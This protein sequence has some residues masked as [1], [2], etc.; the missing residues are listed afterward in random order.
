MSQ[1][2]IEIR[3]AREHNLQDINLK[4]PKDQLIV[5]TG[6]S[7]SGK[8][9]LAIDTI[10]AEGQRRYIESLSTYARQF[11]G[12]IEKPKFDTIDGLSP[13]ISI[14]QKSTSQ[15]PRSTVATI[16]EIYDYLRVLFSRAGKLHCAEC[17][18][19][20]GR[21]TEDE[22]VDQIMAM[23]ENRRLLILA[24]IVIGRR[25][26][27]RKELED[28]RK[29]G[30]ARARI[31]GVVVDLMEDIQLERHKRHN[32]EI[33]VDRIKVRSDI[34]SRVA[35]SVEL[36]LRMSNG[37]LTVNMLDFQDKNRTFSRSYTCTRCQIGYQPLAPRDFSFNSPAGMCPTCRGVG[38]INGISKDLVIPDPDLSINNGAVSL[39]GKIESSRLRMMVQSLADY[40]EIDLNDSWKEL[41]E[42]VQNAILYGTGSRRIPM[43][44]R[45]RGRHRFKRRE[46][47]HGVIPDAEY[48]YH[49]S[50]SQARKNKFEKYVSIIMCPD[51]NGNRLKSEAMS[52][53][54]DDK[55]IVDIAEMT[56][57][58]CL[59]FFNNLRLAERE[60]IIAE[61][62][63]REIRG[64]LEFLANV[65]LEYLSL[66]RTAPTLSG[67]E[68]QRIR[69][70][71]QIG[72]GLHDVV[73]VL[74]EPSIGLHPRDN[75][76][77]LRTLQQL[78]NQGNTVIV[79]EHDEDTMRTADM[80]VDFGPRA[81]IQGGM[82]SDIGTPNEVI[83][84]G[85][86]LTAQYL[87]GDLE[88]EIPNR[89]R[90]HEDSF[91]EII[92][93]KHNNLKNIDVQIPVGILTCVTGVSGSGKSSLI[94]D[95]LYQALARDL[96]RADTT[97][98]KHKRIQAIK[99]NENNILEVQEVSDVIDKVVAINQSPIGRIPRSNPA[100]Y[101]KLFDHIRSLFAGLPE[102]KLRGYKPGRFSFN[103]KGGRCEACQGNGAKKIELQ[104]LADVWVA[105]N[106][107]NGKRYNQETLTVK[108]K[109]KS[110]SDVLN[111]DVQEALEHFKNV[112]NIAKILQT[113]Y[114]VGLDYIKLGQPSPTLS[115]G[116]AQRIKLSRELAKRRTDQTLYILDEPTTGLHFDDV[117]RLL[118]VLHRL[119]DQGSTVI[120]IEHNLEVIKTADYI[121]DLG[122]E[123]GES[124]GFVVA[125]G[126]PEEV[127]QIKGSHTGQ[128]LKRL[129]DRTTEFLK[130]DL[131]APHAV[132]NNEKGIIVQGASEHNL[133][134]VDVKIPYRKL[135]ALTGVSGS[136]KSSLALDII[137]AE[138]QR[139]YIESLSTYARQFLGQL[140]K[141]KVEKI[142]GLSPAI[143]IER[144]ALSKNPRSTVGTV[145]EIYDYLRVLY[146]RIGRAHCPQCKKPVGSQSSQQIIDKIM[147]QPHGI[148]I[149]VMSPLKLQRGENYQEAFKRLQRLGFARVE[150][151]NVTHLLDQAPD[152]KATSKYDVKIVVDR[153]VAS[154]EEKSRLAEA[155]ETA[156]AQ[157]VGTVAIRRESR[158]VQF[159]RSETMGAKE[160]SNRRRQRRRNQDNQNLT[161]TTQ[162]GGD[163][164]IVYST[165]FAC[166]PCSLSFDELTPQHFSFNSSIGQC[167]TCSG[168]GTIWGN[169]CHS[170]QGTRLK[171]LASHVTIG[172]KTISELT[173]M[174]IRQTVH[175][176]NEIG[177][178]PHEMEIGR[179]LVAETRKRLQFL[180][181]IGLHYLTLNRRAPTISG[182]EMQRVHLASQLGSGLTGI[183]YVL[184]EPTTGLHQRDNQRLIKALKGLRDLGN[185]VL[186]IEHDPSTIESSDHVLDFGPGAGI[187]GGEII[188][189]GSPSEIKRNS[190]SLTGRYLSKAEEISIPKERRQGSGNWLEIKHAKKNNLK[191]INVKI[192]F[193]TLTCVTGV[194]GSGKS[195]LVDGVLL[196]SSVTSIGDALKFE[197]REENQK[198]DL[199]VFDKVIN[200]DQSPIGETPRSNAAT[201]TDMFTKI[202]TLFASLPDAKVRGFSSGR[203]SFN[204]SGGR[205][206][207][208]QGLG[209]NQIEMHFLADVWLEC[210]SC[211]GTGYNRETLEVRY[212]GKN[213][214]DI[215]RMPV[216]EALE[217]FQDIPT[218]EKTLQL[219]F[220]VGLDYIQL[221]Q[222][223]TTLS[224]GESQRI[225]L[226]AELGK[227]STGKTLYVMD[228]PTTGLH[229][230]DIQKLLNVINRLVNKG[231]TIVIIEHNMDVIKS[232]D[233][234]I[235]L[236]P[237][238]G[239][240]GGYLIAMGTPEEVASIDQS[241]TGLFLRD[242]LT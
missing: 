176:F 14:S 128:Y 202:R 51:C 60:T 35:E 227:R 119:V 112:P 57:N 45:Q 213:I 146:S 159:G 46:A 153:L 240:E 31:N 42:N 147:D 195:S 217:I 62:V 1:E 164:I 228:E 65:G 106:V 171:P 183:T 157:S 94:N 187:L 126:T 102:S 109:D 58:D 127:T 74:D 206:E 222:S 39:W 90:S 132:G 190:Q 174:P 154:E 76:R 29:A 145:T 144:Q 101:S 92:E 44:Y 71:S 27:Y 189:T 9:S 162:E 160:V 48:Q 140:K 210:E 10:Y 224:S 239:K 54:I 155:V 18:S 231:N 114:D 229:F 131:R 80:I 37:I 93:A 182:G 8:S 91:L 121:I 141:P 123:G 180:K 241:H 97:P 25:G 15:N 208:C 172:D 113:L 120:V 211:N 13:S 64:R 170:C 161:P 34:R 78:R 38:T 105:C 139:R 63:L 191:D 96:M 133:K 55:S 181:E 194:S 2:F 218:I 83:T 115:G 138:G 136:G 21:Q 163:Q 207:L 234:I 41:P 28:A 168:F 110:I 56:I 185:T 79:V 221:G 77:L 167:P 118:E 47:F 134:S 177:L 226:A 49:R 89:R 203:F 5:F 137:Y 4:L 219:L 166:V 230:E 17:N 68:S 69:L 59:E 197:H 20:L 6:V 205:C 233:W 95:I 156:I 66:N 24:P 117:K 186:V 75:N 165:Q 235:D 67:G 175:F 200:I 216:R 98:G 178:T 72:A 130:E 52:V 204:I 84:N 212:K 73:Y 85:S 36:A 40:F 184:D 179:E 201:Y 3:G 43:I 125:T 129:L 237:E 11:I 16:T 61:G 7:G 142:E 86:S 30:Y 193:G 22:I 173:A 122:P 87:R 12:Q 232:A 33:V 53:K 151:N 50:R 88:I 152:L 26:E 103:V 104:L 188:A 196:Q 148:R 223:S 143:A 198:V 158:S 116:E 99:C 107:C 23:P 100:T 149:Y 238:G 225:K 236:G 242:V 82:I 135:T 169:I 209:Y 214:A 199:S 111:L 124:G 150:V 192:P 81:G 70:A 32:I 108:Y 19:P 215:L 220:D